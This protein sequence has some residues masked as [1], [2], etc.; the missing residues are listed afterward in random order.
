M[1][2]S[3]LGLKF[4]ALKLG[5]AGLW[6]YRKGS[7]RLVFFDQTDQTYGCDRISSIGNLF[8]M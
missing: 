1:F 3:V 8:L 7:N 4:E 6:I 5:S 2:G